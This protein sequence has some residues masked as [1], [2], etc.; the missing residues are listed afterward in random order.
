[1]IYC[2]RSDLKQYLG[3]SAL[4]DDAIAYALRAS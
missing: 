3:Q 2:R 4:L 1:M